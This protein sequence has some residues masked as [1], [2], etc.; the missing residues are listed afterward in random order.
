MG[1]YYDGYDWDSDG[2]PGE[3]VYGTD[4]YAESW[5]DERWKRVKEFPEYWVSNRGRVYSTVTD[6]FIEGT[7]LRSGYI[8]VSLKIAGERF[9]RYLHRMVAEAFIPN[10][11]NYPIVRHL[12]DDPSN[13]DVENLA[14]G[15]Q[16]DNMRDCIE[17]GRFRYFTKADIERANEVRRTPVIAIRLSDGYVEHFI[18]QQE[19]SRILGISQ[20][21]IFSV[22]HGLHS[23]AKGY[24]FT[25]DKN[26]AD[27]FDWLSYKYQRK[28]VPVRARNIHTGEIREFN[29]ARHASE[30]LGMSEA[31][32]S[33]VLRNKA[34]SAKGW[35]FKY[36]EED[37]YD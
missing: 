24:Y 20:S 37:V 36:I 11:D 22:V 25:F 18:S 35:I 1:L 28:R 12:D 33:N 17:N 21:D 5:Y 3:F 16:T 19:A 14:W 10:P 2:F 34:C 31:S 26:E 9:H 8:D 13:N 29:S 30:I 32:A 7:R 4:V 6:R 15:T 23:N 27:K